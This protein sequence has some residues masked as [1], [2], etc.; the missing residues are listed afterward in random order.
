MNHPRRRADTIFNDMF[1]PDET[2]RVRQEVRQFCED[3]IRPAAHR[4]NTTPE[5]K[6]SFP[7]AEFDAMA[8]AGLYTIPYPAD[9]GG[10]G[11]EFPTLATV[12]VLE[13][14]G[15]HS[16]GLASALYD[17]QAILVGK[18]LERAPATIRNRYLPK[19]IR[20]EFVGC[21]ATSEPEASTDLSVQSM[22]TVATKA[23]GGWKINGCKRWITNSVAGDLILALCRTGE[24]LTMFLAD[25]HSPGVTVSAPDLKMGN[26]AQLT[27]DVTFRDVFV[28]DDHV[29]GNEGGGLRT[30]IGALVL[31]RMGIGAIGVAMAQ[32]AFDYST[33]YMTR[34]KVF[35][36]ELARFQHWQ[37]RFAEHALQIEMARSLYQKAALRFDKEGN[38]D[39]EAAMAKIAGSRLGCDVA[40]DAIQVCG[41]YGFVRTLSGP[42][43]DYPLESIYRDAKIGEIYEGANE[44][45]SWVIAR[46]IFG[47]E[48]TG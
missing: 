33:D 28:P 23:E 37:F 40:R 45:Q 30:A 15:Y 19:L 46:H 3:V 9:V 1:L 18:T 22:Q 41:A 36:R 10:R 7:R 42:G 8:R 2:R 47:R 25:L 44:I 35:G 34:R 11:L 6:E 17:G 24:T 29:V 27:A 31:G 4:L 14:L 26:H 20:G 16:R 38:A 5:S 48:F 32:A 12:T 21:F 39:I 43:Q 13:E